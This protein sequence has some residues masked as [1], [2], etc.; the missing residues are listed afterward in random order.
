MNLFK[1]ITIF[2]LFFVFFLIFSYSGYSK[3]TDSS[4]CYLKPG[5]KV[6]LI[7]KSEGNR[8][9]I[10]VFTDINLCYSCDVSIKNL[11]KISKSKNFNLII[12]FEGLNEEG[13]ELIKSENKWESTV[14][15]DESGLFTSYYQI[16]NKPALLGLY[17]DGTVIQSGKIDNST[18]NEILN[19]IESIKTKIKNENG[20][21]NFLE[22]SRIKVIKNE[23]NI[24]SNGLHVDALYNKTKNEYYIKNLRKPIVFIID[25][26][27]KVIN[28]INK[29]KFDNYGGGI[30]SDES[31]T[32]VVEDSVFSFVNT[33]P[34]FIRTSYFYD[35]Y[36]NI[37]TNSIIIDT[38]TEDKRIKR[39]P[40]TKF[41]SFL[42]S[43]VGYMRL[44]INLKLDTTFK[45]IINYD[46]N[47][48]FKNQFNCPDTVFQLY[49]ISTWF[50]EL[51]AFNYSSEYFITL[52]QFSNKIKF[53]DSNLIKYK[54]IDFKFGESYRNIQSDLIDDK[55]KE[56]YIKKTHMLTRT[57][58][59]LIDESNENILI[60]Y[61]N[62]T[63]PEGETDIFSENKIIDKNIIIIDENGSW[64]YNSPIKTN[65][66]FIPFYFDNG[67]IYGTEI[68]KNKQLEIVIYKLTP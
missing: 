67:L 5:D 4:Y 55:G 20:A 33:L 46:L 66:S 12:V 29:S 18:F 61:Y 23:K 49:K 48:L 44:D 6:K 9:F 30:Y 51:F 14:I 1:N 45:T 36:K 10:Y 38:T 32:W 43:F 31:L 22:I 15:A 58:S 68:N 53:W 62:E 54:E 35:V 52:Q 50:K 17:P 65:P 39:S 2:I 16:K 60:C 7:S 26:T 21:N 19:S 47:G 37:I 63:F 28:E 57:I 25:S 34:G 3:S 13:V 24:M 27:G 11:E 64:K 8:S 59:L 42:N 40:I 41:V 56:F